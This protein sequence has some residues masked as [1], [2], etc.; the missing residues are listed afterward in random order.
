MSAEQMDCC[1]LFYR[2]SKVHFCSHGYILVKELVSKRRENINHVMHSQE[3]MTD[4][5]ANLN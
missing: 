3:A 4:V 2:A 1:R 5:N